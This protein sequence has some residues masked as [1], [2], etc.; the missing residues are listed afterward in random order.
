MKWWIE[1][2]FFTLFIVESTQVEVLNKNI[3]P[4]TEDGADN[5]KSRSAVWSYFKLF[6]NNAVCQVSGCNK[7]Y[8]YTSSTTRML[9]HITGCHRK[10]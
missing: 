10:N 3:G 4:D 8:K 7:T 6:G 1:N 2:F 5:N 9:D